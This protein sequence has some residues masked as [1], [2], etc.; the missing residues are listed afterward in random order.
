MS[1]L[2]NA[3]PYWLGNY[4]TATSSGNTSIAPYLIKPIGEVTFTASSRNPA[5]FLTCDGSVFSKSVFP[6]L[7]LAIGQ[8]YANNTVTVGGT[9]FSWLSNSQDFA[10]PNLQNVFPLGGSV[11]GQDKSNFYSVAIMG[12]SNRVTLNVSNIPPHEH[13]Q[14]QGG[15][16]ATSGAGARAGD[17]NVAGPLTQA[18]IYDSNGT[19]VTASGATPQAVVLPNPPYSIFNSLI[20]ATYNIN[21]AWQVGY[22]NIDSTNNQ[23]YAPVLTN[24]SPLTFSNYAVTLSQGY[25]TPVQMLNNILSSVGSAVAS[26]Y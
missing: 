10:I 24:I 25:F 22:I 16:T 26:Y 7:A 17:P 12:G 3:Y 1:T 2:A 18:G 19:L 15:V 13:I 8:N 11:L 4:T 21:P 9:N 20:R 5:G 6:D 14:Q 23:F